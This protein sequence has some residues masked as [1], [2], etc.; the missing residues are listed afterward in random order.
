M[1]SKNYEA[2]GCKHNLH[3]LII[4]YQLH[5]LYLCVSYEVGHREKYLN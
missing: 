1:S 4:S 3:L 5:V 2:N